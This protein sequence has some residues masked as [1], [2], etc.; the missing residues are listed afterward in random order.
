MTQGQTTTRRAAAGNP[1]VEEVLEL[2][3]AV[4]HGLR[5]DSS[6]LEIDLTMA[7]TRTLFVVEQEGPLP[8]GR[9]GDR[10]GVTLP[11]AS[12]LVDRLTSAGL[13]ERTEDP[14]DR[15]RTLV[16]ASAEGRRLIE[17]IWQ[18]GRQHM[19]KVVA[20]LDARDLAAL[21]RGLG[22]LAREVRAGNEADDG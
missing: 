1:A 7:Q 10:L 14:Q 3:W 21:A 18:R 16:A 4:G 12:H 15:R 6:L 17:S 20:R 11:T 9:I 8:V 22:A 19:R 2:F 13:V 5:H